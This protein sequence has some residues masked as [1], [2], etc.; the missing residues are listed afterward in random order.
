MNGSLPAAFPMAGQVP[1]RVVLHDFSPILYSFALTEFLPGSL[2][3]N[4]YLCHPV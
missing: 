4:H 2:P 1:L 3:S